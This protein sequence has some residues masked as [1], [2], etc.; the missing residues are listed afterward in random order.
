MDMRIGLAIPFQ[1]VN[2]LI[3]GNKK[4]AEVI[5]MFSIVDK[6]VRKVL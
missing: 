1:I 5:L 6:T 4:L 2:A 3:N